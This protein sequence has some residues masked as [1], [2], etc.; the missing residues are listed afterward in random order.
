MSEYTVETLKLTR[1]FGK[2][3]AVQE[4]NLKLR[5]GEIFGLLGPNGSGKTTLIRLIAGILKPTSGTIDILGTRMPNK[6]V[7]SRV[8]Y[9]TQ[10]LALYEELNVRENI[11]FFA[12]M[13]GARD[14][15]SLDKVLRL[16]DLTERQ[17]S[18]VRNLSGGMKRRTSLACALVHDPDVI[19]LDEPTV[20]VDPSLRVSFWDYF[21]RIAGT[22]KTLIVS[23]H[24]MDEAQRCTRLGFVMNGRFI[25]TGTYDEL[26]SR[27]QTD[28]LEQAFLR[29]T[30][31]GQVST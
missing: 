4:V 19:L 12:S 21:R 23:S 3:R 8:G 16:V 24:V 29:F 18:R 11:A 22:G 25:A 28:D 30:A 17:Y 2:L 13:C 14:P 26:I 1:H 20:G 7:M 15:D 10:S 27:A 6:T 9:M 31:E 5:R